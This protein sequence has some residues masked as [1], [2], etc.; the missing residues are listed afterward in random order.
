MVFFRVS[1]LN[2]LN[3]RFGKGVRSYLA[4]S[5]GSGSEGRKIVLPRAFSLAH[6]L[7]ELQ[8]KVD[9]VYI[10]CLSHIVG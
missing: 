1:K 9:D 2:C 8:P 7:A 5:K 4:N 3:S 6:L 10:S